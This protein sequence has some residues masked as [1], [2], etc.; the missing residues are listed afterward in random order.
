MSKRGREVRLGWLPATYGGLVAF[1][2]FAMLGLAGGLQFALLELDV[3]EWVSAPLYVGAALGA[4][5]LLLGSL[6]M[7]RMRRLQRG[8]PGRFRLSALG[9]FGI[10]DSLAFLGVC[11]YAWFLLGA[12]RPSP[13]GGFDYQ[14]LLLALEGPALVGLYATL[15][16]LN[17]ARVPLVLTALSTWFLTPEKFRMVFWAVVDVALLSGFI[18]VTAYLPIDP[19]TD[20]LA[21]VVLP[22]VRL[23]VTALF[24]MRA[25]VRLLPPA[26]DGVE[27]MGF[28]SLVASRHLRAKK[29]NFITIIGVLSIASVTVSSCALTTTLSV[30]GGFRNDLKRKILGNN[31]HVVIDKEHD[32]FGRW[33][34]TL[35]AVREVQGVEAAA[36]YVTGEVMVTSASNLAGAVLRGIDP[37][38]ASEVIDLEA[39]LVHGRL[40]YLSDPDLLLDLPPETTGSIYPMN[41][42]TIRMD[43]GEDE[44]DGVDAD[45]NAG[46][47]IRDIDELL[48]QRADGPDPELAEDLEDLERLI[49]DGPMPIAAPREVL[50]GI[51]VGQELARSLRLYV[52]DEVNVVS[53]LGELGPAGPMPK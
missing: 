12:Y 3:T 39:N 15:V 40:E 7:V 29:S 35:Q 22:A 1:Y 36:P 44:P 19:P 33:V 13:F 17:V 43:D 42:P 5:V 49:R 37:A 14:E 47:P 32:T 46:S 2:I 27:R 10:V 31:A 28:N 18:A 6:T 30:M 38:S 53:P 24:G 34:P 4:P 26:L 52:G 21:D 51:I 23:T 25:L 11:G 20:D 48:G 16:V 50:P 41:I 8:T 9:V 45:V